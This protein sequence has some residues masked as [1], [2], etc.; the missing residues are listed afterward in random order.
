[1]NNSIRPVARKRN[2]VIQ[3]LDGEVLVYDLDSNKAHCLNESA[4][5]VWKNCDGMNDVGE[6][7]KRFNG[8]V[9][10]DFVWLAI[11]QLSELNLLD[12]SVSSP[13]LG[14]S[15]RDVLK[16]IG[17]VSIV[18]LPVV[19]SLAAPLSVYAAT[20]SSAP[21]QPISCAN[22]NCAGV[23][24]TPNGPVCPGTLTYKCVGLACQCA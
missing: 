10:D 4:A 7:A 11:D 22:P 9:N 6:I 16:K 24:C 15:R 20:C 14:S 3:D 17:L 13:H 21:V 1:M 12:T 5:I 23:P 8:K 18:T 2:L 19:S